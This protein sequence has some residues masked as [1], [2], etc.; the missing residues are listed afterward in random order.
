MQLLDIAKIE[1]SAKHRGREYRE[2][3]VVAETNWS[4][5][6]V[7]ICA[8]GKRKSSYDWIR[9]CLIFGVVPLGLEPRTP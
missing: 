9:N 5:F 8:Q 7:R 1:E 4:G 3:P 6:R 2:V